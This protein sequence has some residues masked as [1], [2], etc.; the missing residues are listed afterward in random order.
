M[1][2]MLNRRSTCRKWVSD[3]QTRGVAGTH[4]NG[5]RR[6]PRRLP[7][8]QSAVVLSLGFLC[9]WLAGLASSGMAAEAYPFKTQP[10]EFPATE[11]LRV[12]FE[13]GLPAG[14]QLGD[15]VTIEDGA[16]T[17]G[18]RGLVSRKKSGLVAKFPIQEFDVGISR[19]DLTLDFAGKGYAYFS[20]KLNAYNRQ[21]RVIRSVNIGGEWGR[22]EGMRTWET[23]EANLEFEDIYAVELEIEQ[24]DRENIW[25]STDVREVRL[26]NIIL[27]RHEAR[28]ITGERARH[29]LSTSLY[30]EEPEMKVDNLG[31]LYIAETP[32]RQSF[33]DF[34]PIKRNQHYVRSHWQERLH[35][36]STYKV[37]RAK[38][39]TFLLGVSAKQT[40]L[41]LA[42]VQQGK[43]LVEMYEF[44][45]DDVAEHGF[46]TVWV[47]FT[48][49]L[50]KFDALAA[51]R[52]IAVILRD[53]NWSGLDR[54]IANPNGP[55]PEEFKKTAAANFE[56]YKKLKALVGYQ[57][58]PPLNRN[59]Q[60]M[61]AKAREYLMSLDPEI[62]LVTEESDVYSAE[63]IEAPAPHMGIRVADRRHYIGR[64]WARP[65][66]MY[67]PNYW[68]VAM[69]E[70]YWRRS[71][72]AFRTRYMASLLEIPSG[73][74]FGKKSIS[75]QQDSVDP[76]TAGWT[77]DE[78]AKRWSGWFRYKYPP[79]MLKGMVWKAL[80]AGAS[81]V[82]ISEW[83]P[84]TVPVTTTGTEIL[85]GSQYPAGK[86][87]EPEYLRL[88][89]MSES[90]GWRELGEV[91]RQLAGLKDM[92]AEATLHGNNTARVDN[93][94]I[95]VRTITGRQDPF[96]L[97]L[98]VNRN[99]GE[100][101]EASLKINAETG[102][103]EGF[104]PGNFTSFRVTIES[105]FGLIDLRT[106]E[107]LDPV[108]TN[109]KDRSA[110]YEMALG[111]GEG[112]FYF[113]GKPQVYQNFIDQYNITPSRTLTTAGPDR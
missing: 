110:T 16:G 40:S 42:A 29:E 99:I 94:N 1:K 23:R 75:M 50:E 87:Y 35:I 66:H 4:S 67:H 45:L 89:D 44:F 19:F 101:D 39:P 56:R 8:R 46:N 6:T 12:D 63:Q 98:V 11:W 36:G 103:L 109:L 102:E 86:D 84:A 96:K 9:G 69:T 22:F 55:M 20:A 34:G 68:S 71:H 111:P 105:D 51:E 61:L 74:A 59:Y 78:E 21:G 37:C 30:R 107:R 92:L 18:S 54:W 32:E 13:E 53:P 31:D 48:Q 80:E 17:N 49:E 91:G 27:R 57:M 73:R 52:G 3:G 25:Q 7:W 97:L 26:D 2:R 65:S 47:D 95:R 93:G 112:K 83:G 14:A 64:P 15:G 10:R 100:Y 33:F 113:K 106:G 70:G 108:S 41:A 28:V 104:V 43:T 72:D 81:G 82:L 24:L 85:A 90:D 58:N 38:L 79:N 60:P 77:Y 76:A 88:S 5:P 62:Q